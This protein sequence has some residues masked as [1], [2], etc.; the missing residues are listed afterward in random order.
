M[1]G[2]RRD[3]GDEFIVLACDGIWDCISNQVSPHPENSRAN[4]PSPL[5]PQTVE[6]ITRGGFVLHPCSTEAPSWGYPV[7][8]LGAI[9]SF[10][11]GNI[12]K[13]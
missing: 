4:D 7:F 13:S 2:T 3:K 10:L 8:V 9:C 1:Y 6:L 5:T 12:V 11:W